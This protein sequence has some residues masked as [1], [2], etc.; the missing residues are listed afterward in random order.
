MTVNIAEN[1]TENTLQQEKVDT[2]VSQQKP[3]TNI[4]QENKPADETQEDPNWRAFR[5]ARKK[6]KAERE[7]AQ[8]KAAEKEAEVAALKA[9]M[10]AA[11]SKGMPQQQYASEQGSYQQ[12]ETEDER[13]NKKVEAALEKRLIQEEN[14]RQEREKQQLPQR[15]KQAFPDYDQV[16]NEENGNYLEYHY[17]EVYRTLL[18][19]PENFETCADIYKVVKKLIPNAGGAK[20]E[21]AKAEINQNKPRS[22]SSA[23][24]TQPGESTNRSS[25]QE[26]ESRRAAR[27]QEMQKILKSVG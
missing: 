21:A 27:Y 18:R 7:A 24:I 22:I 20:K 8:R 16:V 17:P 9:A 11:F 12:E 6:D 5:E 10:E 3:D 15:L 23:G 4:A 14:N 13:I 1:K 19:Q 2:I 26:I 25:M